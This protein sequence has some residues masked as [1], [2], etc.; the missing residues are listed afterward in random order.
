MLRYEDCTIKPATQHTNN[1][2]G[3]DATWWM[4]EGKVEF[5]TAN[6]ALGV[7][8]VALLLWVKKA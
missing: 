2:L 4:F 8:T 3:I 7:K 5:S 6:L 1:L